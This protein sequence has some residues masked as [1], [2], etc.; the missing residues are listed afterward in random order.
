MAGAVD[1]AVDRLTQHSNEIARDGVCNWLSRVRLIRAEG[2]A[3]VDLETIGVLVWRQFQVNTGEGQS[4]CLRQP[5][6]ALGEII[7]ELHGVQG[8]IAPHRCA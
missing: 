7:G 3:R 5:Q 6:A 8:C 2:G 4:E 1:K